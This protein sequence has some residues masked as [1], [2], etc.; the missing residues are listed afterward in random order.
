M[1]SRLVDRFWS[2]RPI[3]G[4][5]VVSE[6]ILNRQYSQT[7]NPGRFSGTTMSITADGRPP[8]KSPTEL[9]WMW[10]VWVIAISGLLVNIS[11]VWVHQTA[12][13]H[14]VEMWGC[15]GSTWNC[16]AVWTSSYAYVSGI[17]LT[18]YGIADSCIV[19]VSLILSSRLRGVWSALIPVV[20]TS[21][22]AV[23]AAWL[24]G[25]M[26]FQ[27]ETW[28]LGCLTVHLVNI[29]RFLLSIGRAENVLMIELEGD[30]ILVSGTKCRRSIL[31]AV[32]SAMALCCGT[33]AFIVYGRTEAYAMVVPVPGIAD[34]LAFV[35]RAGA[36]EAIKTTTLPLDTD[37]SI[38][39]FSCLT[40]SHCRQVHQD[41]TS[42]IQQH[43]GAIR[44]EYRFAPLSA[45]CNPHWRNQKSTSRHEHACSLTKWLLAF[46]MTDPTDF[47]RFQGWM[48]EHQQ[49]LTPAGVR[50]EATKFVDPNI[51]D[52]AIDSLAVN[53]RLEID[54]SLA[55]E[56]NVTS[57]PR[58]FVRNG[59]VIGPLSRP[60]L[61]RILEQFPVNTAGPP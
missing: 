56:L 51:I 35:A 53:Q 48:Y 60:N 16:G 5:R 4:L 12:S 41:L 23:V 36:N 24:I 15:G 34:P 22:G 37:H 27:L 30:P 11:L 50:R 58:L 17:P 47:D 1:F 3:F 28:C 31:W 59:A 7:F 54:V 20:V 55:H 6:D 39:L 44:V 61:Q 42:L 10:S 57:V 26:L 49:S 33:V 19:L 46:A 45:E 9:Y 40:C 14:P 13:H 21:V 29:G 18:H 2:V 52:A 43:P 25:V 8:V 38:V 32:L